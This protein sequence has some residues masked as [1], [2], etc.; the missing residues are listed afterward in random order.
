MFRVLDPKTVFSEYL[1]YQMKKDEFFDNAMSDVKGMKM[2]RGKRDTI[3]SFEFVLPSFKEQKKIVNKL[4]KIEQEI[5]MEKQ[6]II[7]ASEIKRKI[8]KEYLER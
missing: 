4:N 6:K 2:P 7:S 8:M 5:K 3:A 1:F